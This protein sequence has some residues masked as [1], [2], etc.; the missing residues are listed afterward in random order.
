MKTDRNRTKQQSEQFYE[1][2]L[3]IR[4]ALVP[5]LAYQQMVA[6]KYEDATFRASLERVIA[7]GVE[8]VL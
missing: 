4:R 8:R 6:E 1:L 2:E 5:S 7:G 3:E